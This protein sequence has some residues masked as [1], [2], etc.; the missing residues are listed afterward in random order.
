MKKLFTAKGLLLLALI[1]TQSLS[2][3][4]NTLGIIRLQRDSRIF[5][6]TIGNNTITMYLK[7]HKHHP[8]NDEIYSVKGWYY[9]EDKETKISLVGINDGS[10]MLYSFS[11]PDQEN[12]VVEFEF[13]GNYF[14][15]ENYNEKLYVEDDYQ[16]GEWTKNDTTLSVTLYDNDLCITSTKEYLLFDNEQY[17]DLS[18]FGDRV[19]N[20][21]LLGHNKDNKALLSYKYR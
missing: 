20:F 8:S 9:G 11:T 6:G 16:K 3:Q 17:F 14:E 2:A 13:K 4:D 10:L 7:L 1:I 21:S 12:S 15:I 5:E 19:W 18:F